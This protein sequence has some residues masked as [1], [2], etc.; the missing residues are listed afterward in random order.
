M[1]QA[2]RIGRD[3]NPAI[4]AIWPPGGIF[5]PPAPEPDFKEAGKDGPAGS[6]TGRR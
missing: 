1:E 2:K 6:R 3:E 5:A 4:V